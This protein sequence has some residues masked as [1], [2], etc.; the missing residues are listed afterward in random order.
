VFS[1]LCDS[2]R[3]I[4]VHSPP[5]ERPDR[6]SPG[7]PL[8]PDAKNPFTS[9]GHDLKTFFTQKDT[10]VIVGVFLPAAA[11][12]HTSDQAGIRESQE[13]LTDSYFEVGNIAGNFLVQT[14]PAFG[15]WAIGKAIDNQQT[16]VVGVDLV[17]AQFVSQIVVQGGMSRLSANR[18][19]MSDVIMGAAVGLAAGRA[20]TVGVGG[21]KFDMSV[22][23]TQGGAAVNFTKR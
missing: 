16:A 2:S 1:R 9:L 12:A 14:G 6:C 19:H 23:P 8:L 3:S 22:A 17:R 13:H 4:A 15:T 7:F 11:V 18:H 10:R 21:A 5:H 20:V